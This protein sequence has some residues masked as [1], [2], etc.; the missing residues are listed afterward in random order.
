MVQFY[1]P[2][3][4]HLR[5]LKVRRGLRRCTVPRAAWRGARRVSTLPTAR[6]R[7]HAHG[8][9]VPHRVPHRVPDRVPDRVPHL[10]QVPG[11]GISALSWEGGSL[12]VALAVDSYIYFANIRPDYK[13][14]F[15]GDTLVCAYTQPDRS[16]QTVMF[17]NTKTDGGA[18]GGGGGGGGDGGGCVLKY[19][20]QLLDIKAPMH[21][22]R[23][24]VHRLHVHG[25]HV[26]GLHVHR[27]QKHCT[28]R[29]QTTHILCAHPT[30]PTTPPGVRRELRAR[31]ACRGC[32]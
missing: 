14:G 5:T 8:P 12:R 24:H 4:Q 17:W 18:D 10:V 19:V 31:H 2:Q 32:S 9:G 30:H 22:H 20:K 15:F 6:A 21:M 25:L 16:D 26:H 23:L 27:L 29:T 28:L 11:S 7:A 13:W 1:S 3:G